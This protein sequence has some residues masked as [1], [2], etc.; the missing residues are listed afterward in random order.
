M[1]SVT[2]GEVAATGRLYHGS[3]QILPAHPSF[4]ILNA[5]SVRRRTVE[6]IN[7]RQFLGEASLLTVAALSPAVARDGVID[8]DGADPDG[9]LAALARAGLQRWPGRLEYQQRLE[10]EL[11]IIRARGASRQFLAA[12]EVARFA[13]EQGIAVSP[14]R[15]AAPSS[16]V[17]Y[18]LGV[19]GVDPIAHGLLFERFLNSHL[20][21]PPS[22]CLDVCSAA[23]VIAHAVNRLGGTAAPAG[24]S[25]ALDLGL[26]IAAL[27]ALASLRPR[28]VDL[29]KIPLDDPA[30]YERLAAGVP[31]ELYGLDTSPLLRDLRPER[32]ED[33]VAA[34]ALGRRGSAGLREDLVALRHRQRAPEPQ[35][36]LVAPLLAGT[37]GL[38]L[39]QEQVMQIAV[40]VARYSPDDADVFRRA[41]AKARPEAVATHRD[42]FVVAAIRAGVPWLDAVLIF[43]RLERAAPL[44][45][46]RSHAVPCALILYW[47]AYLEAHHTEVRTGA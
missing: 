45:F 20:A 40:T 46:A 22:I 23:P 19:T 35:H 1:S 34:F 7:R 43:S 38:V 32:F 16:L 6:G 42:R 24:D 5:R 4:Y 3:I 11:A 37:R 25:T 15:G 12:A 10:R 44:T 33:V 30:T 28:A 13:R 18:A 41:L 8:L 31:V 9:R 39:Y 17:A 27:P 2:S 21:A 36:A 29:A 14:G 47:A 26:E